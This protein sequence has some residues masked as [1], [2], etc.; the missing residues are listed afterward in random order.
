MSEYVFI[1]SQ[2]TAIPNLDILIY[3]VRDFWI[4]NSSHKGLSVLPFRCP[5]QEEGQT[6]E[7][8]PHPGAVAGQLGSQWWIKPSWKCFFFFAFATWLSGCGHRRAGEDYFEPRCLPTCMEPQSHRSALTDHPT[9]HSTSSVIDVYHMNIRSIANVRKLHSVHLWLLRTFVMI[10][11][12]YWFLC[13][14]LRPPRLGCLLFQRTGGLTWLGRLSC[15]RG[16]WW[17]GCRENAAD[18]TS[19]GSFVKPCSSCFVLISHALL[20]LFW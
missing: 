18:V 13:W 3:P 7:R 12:Y 19:M 15:T 8:L 20:T 6:V 5:W 11:G 14:C 9:S 4:S 17:E 16:I 2:Q 1:C 10:I